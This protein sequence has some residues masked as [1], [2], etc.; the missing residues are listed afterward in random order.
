VRVV[1]WNCKMAFSR[2]RHLIS[3]LAA[4]IAIVPECSKDSIC[5]RVDDAFDCRWIG[6][7]PDKKGLGVLVARPWRLARTGK[8]RSKWVVPLWIDGPTKFLLV[9]VWTMQV[10]GGGAKSY[11]G[12]AHEALSKNPRWMRNNR[13]IVAGDFNSN[14]IWDDERTTNG[15]SA[16]VKLLG[17]RGIV[18]AYHEFFSERQGEETRPTYYFWHRKS[19]GYHID[20][21]FLPSRWAQRIKSVEVGKYRRW[22]KLSD[23]VPLLVE[24]DLKRAR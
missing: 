18:S 11:I 7:R 5:E 19:R 20:Y 21:V 2:K 15:H 6:G 22:A 24:V 12:Q 13:V 1:V 17:D 8:P 14:K 4:H 16:V 10:S 23:H 3:G 9:A